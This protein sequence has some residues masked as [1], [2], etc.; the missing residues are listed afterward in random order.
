MAP[1]K[2]PPGPLSSLGSPIPGP[3]PCS[4]ASPVS[5]FPPALFLTQPPAPQSQR[6]LHNPLG[7]ANVAKDYSQRPPGRP[8]SPTSLPN[9]QD[10][11]L[12]SHPPGSPGMGSAPA[13]SQPEPAT[14]TPT[15][16]GLTGHM[17]PGSR[18]GDTPLARAAQLVGALSCSPKGLGSIPGQGC[19]SR[20]CYQSS[21]PQPGWVSRPFCERLFQEGMA[22]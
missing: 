22:Q 9:A 18:W 14:A 10:S 1:G 8:L 15:H 21:A 7:A 2:R 13:S 11:Q 5:S 12:Q 3:R 17:A 6:K 19:Q 16:T 20:S 4:G